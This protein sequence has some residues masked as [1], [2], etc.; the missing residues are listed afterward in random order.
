[1]KAPSSHGLD[2]KFKPWRKGKSGK[3]N[4]ANS[5]KQQLRG[6]QR[7]Y[8]KKSGKDGQNED[9]AQLA[10][11]QGRID[12]LQQQIDTR[13]LS[14]KERSNA[15]KSHKM[16]FIERQRLTRH[17]KQ[18][19]KKQQQNEANTEHDL[20]KL[21][22]DQVYV[23][24][25][26]LETSYLSLFQNSTRRQNLNKR[27]LFKMASQRKRVLENLAAAKPDSVNS[28]NTGSL[29]RAN[30]IHPS[31]YERIKD[32]TTWSTDQERSTFEV[33][34]SGKQEKFDDDRFPV[35]NSAQM[36]LEA[37]E[38]IEKEADQAEA[39]TK[40]VLEH[41]D[42]DSSSESSSSSSSSDDDD[43]EADPLTEPSQKQI[44]TTKQDDSDDDSSSKEESLE[45]QNETKKEAS[46][47]D[48]DS[49]SSSSSD[50]DS[51]S[52]DEVT[53][54]LKVS[55]PLSTRP[56]DDSQ[57]GNDD[58][59]FLVAASGEADVF[60]NAKRHVP[61]LDEAVGDKSKGWAT[62]RLP[63]GQFRKKQRRR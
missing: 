3:S 13:N 1:M 43:D 25:Y 33:T 35:S 58:D 31:Q 23:A 39:T 27:L 61:A 57:E 5:L 29:Q 63:P 52:S 19:T 12:A 40:A 11:L 7:L 16:R 37:Q 51:S 44:A 41:S 55:V 20:W 10:D 46:D 60:A 56:P 21:A 38:K 36:V 54:Q 45:P 22:L 26:P 24:H 6:L 4:N 34:D 2:R 50:D 9:K 15:K 48:G 8:K 17:Y 32:V 62:Q 53:E 49:S 18:L 59:D 30:W 42:A 28:N 47:S 14:E